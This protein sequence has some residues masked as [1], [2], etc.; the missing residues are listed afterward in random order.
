MNEKPRSALFIDGAYLDAVQ[1]SV[2]WRRKIE[3]GRLF[4]LL[5]SGT[6]LFRA[7]YYH[8]EPYQSDPPTEQEQGRLSRRRAFLGA[9]ARIP[10]CKV[11][12]GHL[13]YRGTTAEG[14]PVYVQKGADVLLAIDMVFLTMRNRI[15][16][17]VLLAGDGDFL[18]AVKMVQEQGVSV[19]LWHGPAAGTH[20]KL[21]EECD[22]RFEL[23]EGALRDCLMPNRALDRLPEGEELP[24]A[25]KGRGSSGGYALRTPFRRVRIE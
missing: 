8:C 1:R 24:G 5:G 11:R 19:V 10:K 16:R 15:D 17:A 23:T 2:L 12:L 25:W 7:Y 21:W 22:E 13:V 9:I 18:P 6:E 14:K 4:S 3:F 20:G